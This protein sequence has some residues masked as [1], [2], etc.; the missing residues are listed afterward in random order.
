[1]PMVQFKSSTT[2]DGKRYRMNERLSCSEPRA[3]RL[4]AMNA[5]EL[6]HG[7]AVSAGFHTLVETI[8]TVRSDL[9]KARPPVS[10]ATREKAAAEHRAMCRR[11]PW[12]ETAAQS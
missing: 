1:M 6:V 10:K 3:A 7:Q 9:A 4:V 8:R 11:F 12:L 2:Y 5:A